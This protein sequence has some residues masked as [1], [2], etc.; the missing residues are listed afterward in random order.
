M[1]K[2]VK[3]RITLEAQASVLE[4]DMYEREEVS[5]MIPSANSKVYHPQINFR[6][7]IPKMQVVRIEKIEEDKEWR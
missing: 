6:Y 5:I 7:G 2:V 3:W 4:H 1:A